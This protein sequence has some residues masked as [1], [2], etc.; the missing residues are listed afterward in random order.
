VFAKVQDWEDSGCM[1][2]GVPTLKCLEVVYGNL[3]FISA[4]FVMMILF[5]MWVLGGVTYLT[6][7]GEP[8]KVEKAQNIIKWALLG[9]ILFVSSYALLRVIDIAFLGG[10]GLIFRLN[11]P[12]PD[13]T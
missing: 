12:G 2:D 8:A 3:L 11:I 9:T 6:S 7:L 1:V 5:V 10:E 4:G 13:G